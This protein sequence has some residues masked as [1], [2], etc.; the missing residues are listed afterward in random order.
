MP[1]YKFIVING[2]GSD[3]SKA[4]IQGKDL[5]IVTDLFNSI[6]YEVVVENFIIHNKFSFSEKPF[7]C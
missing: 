5:K 1:E 3:G 6:G 2:Q 4:E 7:I